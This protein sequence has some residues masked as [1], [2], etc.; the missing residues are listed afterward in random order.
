[1][2][3]TSVQTFISGLTRPIIEFWRDLPAVRRKLLGLLVVLLLVVSGIVVWILNQ[4]QY[5]V[6][7]SGL[8]ASEAGAI[9]Q[10]L[11][12][13]KIEA[14]AKGTD[15]IL[16]PRDQVDSLR[17]D[18]AAE[19]L[20]QDG[21]TLDI[22]QQGTGFGMT[23]T[24]KQIYRRYQLQQDLENAIETFGTVVKARVSLNIPEKSSFLIEDQAEPATAA[25][26]LTLRPGTQLD[27][28]NVQAIA[29]LIEKSVPGLLPEGITIIDSDMNV[30][31]VDQNEGQMLTQDQIG[32]EQQVEERLKK[33]VLS[34]LQPVFGM[35]QVLA[36]VSVRLN[37]DDQVVESIT[38]EPVSADNTGVIKSI[39]KILDSASQADAANQVSGADA[40]GAAAPVY[41]VAAS[42]T[43]AYEKNS[44]RISYEVSSIKESLVKAKGTLSDLSVSVVLDQNAIQGIDYSQDVANMIASAVGVPATAIVVTALPFNGQSSMTDSWSTYNLI[45]QQAQKWQ[46]TQFFVMLGAALLV[47]LVILGLIASI[48][49]KEKPARVK[50]QAA[51]GHKEKQAGSAAK[52]IKLDKTDEVYEMFPSLNPNQRTEKAVDSHFSVSLGPDHTLHLTDD[53]AVAERYVRENPELAANIIRGWL[54]EESR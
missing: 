13:R 9:L 12:E 46:Q 15:T 21:K 2:G 27:A 3:T 11:E 31:S 30:L 18:L 28:T 1:M 50:S 49:R 54:A 24:D 48:F 19:G 7:F 4:T 47:A 22:L 16:V 33:Q 52:R 37:F 36:E 41:P 38:F 51:T 29:S 5:A 34:L 10:Q 44:E 40:N 53:K 35:E 17:M 45:E 6:L 23:E 43:T 42:D 32:L 26:L 25:V 14:K 20:P 39:E 8:T